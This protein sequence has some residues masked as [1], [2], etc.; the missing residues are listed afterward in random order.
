MKK[1]IRKQRPAMNQHKFVQWS[2]FAFSGWCKSA[3]CAPDALM[4]MLL[5]PLLVLLRFD[6]NFYCLNLSSTD[7]EADFLIPRLVAPALPP[8]V[9]APPAAAGVALALSP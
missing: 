2:H 1:S 9:P 4:L 3:A 7:E 5:L 8:P 6:P